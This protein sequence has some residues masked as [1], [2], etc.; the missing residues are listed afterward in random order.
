MVSTGN[1]K[2]KLGNSGGETQVEALFEGTKAQEEGLETSV[3]I[4]PCSIPALYC[5]AATEMC[6][7]ICQL[8]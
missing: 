2:S 1:S 7:E 4:Q 6:K 8:H 5:K 3:G